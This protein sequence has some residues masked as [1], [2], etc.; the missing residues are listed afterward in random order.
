MCIIV[1]N[2]STRVRIVLKSFDFVRCITSTIHRMELSIFFANESRR[3]KKKQIKATDLLD[4]T[5]QLVLL[6]IFS[7]FC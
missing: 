5:V 1:I 2:V 7:S 4:T 6:I 3:A